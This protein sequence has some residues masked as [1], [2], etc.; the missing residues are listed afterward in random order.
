MSKPHPK[1]KS[2]FWQGDHG[3]GIASLSGFIVSILPEQLAQT[4]RW[5]PEQWMAAA[6]LCDAAHALFNAKERHFVEEWMRADFVADYTFENV[7]AALGMKP[8]YVQRQLLLRT[9]CVKPRALA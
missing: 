5:R 3:G 6:L 9:E 7:C 2:K 1:P 4:P 8:D